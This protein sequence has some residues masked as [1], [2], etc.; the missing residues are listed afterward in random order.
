MTEKKPGIE[1]TL[2]E[3]LSER[4]ITIGTYPCR[5]YKAK[6]KGVFLTDTELSALKEQHAKELEEAFEEGWLRASYYNECN[7]EANRGAPLIKQ[8]FNDYQQRGGK[9]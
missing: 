3:R 4:F 2:V 7:R 5:D 1:C 8:E 6:T 9:E